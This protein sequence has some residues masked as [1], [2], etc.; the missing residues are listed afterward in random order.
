M[1]SINSRESVRGLTWLCVLGF[2]VIGGCEAE[3]PHDESAIVTVLYDGK[4][5]AD[6]SVRLHDRIDGPPLT[7][8]ITQDNGEARLPNI[9]SPEPAEYFVSLESFSDGGWILDPRAT[10]RSGNALKLKSFAE[11]LHQEIELPANSVKPL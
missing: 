7:Q 8:A 10:Q 9:P 3:S 6:V 4:P 2:V 5:L 1:I 11:R